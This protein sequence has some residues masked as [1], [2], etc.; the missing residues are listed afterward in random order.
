DVSAHLDAAHF[1]NLSGQCD[2]PD[3]LYTGIVGACGRA[4]IDTARNRSEMMAYLQQ[5]YDRLVQ[6]LPSRW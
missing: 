1:I 2:I 4:C 5:N 3:A 6:H